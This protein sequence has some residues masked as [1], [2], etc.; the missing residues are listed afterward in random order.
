[1]T[2]KQ[3]SSGRDDEASPQQDSAASGTGA[4]DQPTGTQDPSENGKT[5]VVE[6]EKEIDRIARYLKGPTAFSA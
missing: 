2:S 1:M 5:N 3:P 4:P 6:V